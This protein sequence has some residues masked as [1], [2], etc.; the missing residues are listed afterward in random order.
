MP[1]A[2]PCR[3]W[4]TPRSRPFLKNIAK[5]GQARAGVGDVPQGTQRP[6]RR[7]RRARANGR[8]LDTAAT[9]AAIAAAIKARGTGAAAKPIAVEVASVAPK[10][11][12]EQA[13]KRGPLM[14]ALGTWKTWFPVSERN[15]FGAN[16]WRPAEII[17][18]TVLMPGPAVRVVERA[19]AR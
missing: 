15:Y 2:R 5:V 7:G 14:E 11:T 18:G 9:V 6:D 3:S 1:R 4:T 12:T 19:R 13:V 10:F 8:K 17:D 16:I